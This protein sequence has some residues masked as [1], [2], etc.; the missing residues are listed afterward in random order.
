MKS[1]L[2]SILMF[3]AVLAAMYTGLFGVLASPYMMIFAIICVAAA[4]FF[5][6][7]VLGNPFTSADKDDKNDKNAD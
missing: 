7:R 2:V 4:L 3:M 6:F 1:V 5:A